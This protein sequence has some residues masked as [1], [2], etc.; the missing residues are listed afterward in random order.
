MIARRM[1]TQLQGLGK[2]VFGFGERIS[3]E[4]VEG[5]AQVVD[6]EQRVGTQAFGHAVFFLV[7]VDGFVAHV[8]ATVQFDDGLRLY[9]LWQNAQHGK[10]EK[11]EKASHK[12]IKIICPTPLA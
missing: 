3:V 12:L 11:R 2:I 5:A 9:C 10:T 1:R 7:V 4:C 6:I 8:S